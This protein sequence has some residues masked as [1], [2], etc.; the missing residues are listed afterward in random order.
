MKNEIQDTLLFRFFAGQTSNE[1]TDRIA[2]WLN[3]NPEENQKRLNETHDLFLLSILNEP[4]LTPKADKSPAYRFTHSVLFRYAGGIAAALILAF[5]ANYLFFSHRLNR[6]VNKTASIEAPA[7]QHVRLALSDGTTVELNAKSKITYP[8]VFAGKER[9]VQL[10][11]EAR[12]D[13]QHDHE[14]PF[15][16][17][18]FACDVEVRGTQF[19][20]IAD[21][22]TREFS[23]ALFQGCVAVKNKMNDEQILMEPNTVVDLKNGHLYLDRLSDHDEF[24]WTEG[25]VSFGGNSF[26][27]VSAKLE[28]YYGVEIDIE[29]ENLPVI[30]YKQLKIRISEGVDH[31]LRILQRASDFSYEYDETSNRIVIR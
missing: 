6:L 10:E 20:V 9:R 24:L 21:Q 15:I 7:G 5:A 30:R 29:R 18:T 14:H 28:K 25:I 19:N 13:V 2:A 17:E 1:E 12:F 23:T 16:V 8:P 3:E 31:A 27:E 4:D 11:G 22:E 26:A